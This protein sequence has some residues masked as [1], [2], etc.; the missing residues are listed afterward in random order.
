MKCILLN[1]ESGKTHI[2]SVTKECAEEELENWAETNNVSLS[3]SEYMFVEK[4]Q[5]DFED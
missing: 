1:F 5:I 4:L 3:N 2:I